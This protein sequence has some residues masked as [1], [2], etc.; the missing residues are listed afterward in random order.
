V[1]KPK[2]AALQ[3]STFDANINEFSVSELIA[4]QRNK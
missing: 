4:Q 3:S 2:V 1:Y